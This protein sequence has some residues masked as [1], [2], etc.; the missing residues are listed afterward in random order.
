MTHQCGYT[1]SWKA[2]DRPVFEEE[3]LGRIQNT[4]GGEILLPHP[5]GS[6]KSLLTSPPHLRWTDSS[7]QEN[8]QPCLT[9]YPFSK[10]SGHEQHVALPALAKWRSVTSQEEPSQAQGAEAWESPCGPAQPSL[11]L[12]R[13]PSGTVTISQLF[14]NSEVN[15]IK[16]SALQCQRWGLGG[17]LLGGD[18]DQ[19]KDSR[20]VL[21]RKKPEATSVTWGQPWM[22]THSFVFPSFQQSVQA[23][24]LAHGQ[25]E[26]QFPNPADG[27]SYGL[28]R[29][30]SSILLP[31]H[32]LLRNPGRNDMGLSLGSGLTAISP[33]TYSSEQ[34]A[35]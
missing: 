5:Q 10:P 29:H 27:S 15:G 1:V 19:L 4:N 24:S 17:M 22:H 21:S 31:F 33:Q 6:M 28:F 30:R 2:H 3:K 23:A 13:S 12:F 16:T 14:P 18:Q 9:P 11:K 26:S 34:Q 35:T 20:R 25:L 8:A 7:H 32:R